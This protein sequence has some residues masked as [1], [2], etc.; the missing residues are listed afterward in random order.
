MLV[1]ISA[2]SESQVGRLQI[3]GRHCD[4]DDDELS[5]YYL[6]NL[7]IALGATIIEAVLYRP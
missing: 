2:C 5:I 3:N 6:Q 1:I 7:G 4:K